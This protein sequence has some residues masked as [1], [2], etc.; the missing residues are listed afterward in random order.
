MREALFALE[1][2]ERELLRGS[3]VPM[4]DFRATLE[5]QM[6]QNDGNW[7]KHYHGDGNQQRLARAFSFSDRAR[8]YLPQEAVQ[9]SIARLLENLRQVRIPASLLSQYMPIQ[10][11]M[12]RE[13]R[14]RLRPALSGCMRTADKCPAAAIVSSC[15]AYSMRDENC[16][17]QLR[18][19]VAWVCVF[20]V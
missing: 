5:Y 20:P 7:K 13:G 12:V 14:L 1:C 15:G 16:R 11:T 18:G 17:E 3:G 19:N 2:I 9:H 4:S 8:Y 6:L 10:Y